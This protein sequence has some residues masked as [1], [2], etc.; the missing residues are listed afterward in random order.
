MPPSDGKPNEILDGRPLTAEAFA[1]ARGISRGRASNILSE[2]AQRGELRR[3]AKGIYVRTAE[4]AGRLQPTSAVR[5]IAEI[6]TQ[7]A[8]GLEP[9]VFSTGQLAPYMH[10]TPTHELVLVAVPRAQA[11]TVSRI[12]SSAGITA[13]PVQRPSDLDRLLDLPGE[14]L[15]AVTAVGDTRATE[16]FLGIRLARPER[17]LVDLIVGADRLHL[18]IYPEDTREI[19]RSLLTDYS[20]SVSKALDYARRRGAH[21]RVASL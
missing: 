15:V 11:R 8:P 19:A 14:P 17:A 13:L 5:Q 6:L 18:P 9:V 16:P 21:A 2:M 20:F 7:A 10:N 12:L 1:A 4:R 3:L